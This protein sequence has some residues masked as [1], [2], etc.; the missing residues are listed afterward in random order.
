[1]DKEVLKEQLAERFQVALDG[2]LAAV[3]AA[4]EGRWIEA[5]EWVVRERFQKL[6][7]DCYQDVLQARI[8]STP[9]EVAGGFERGHHCILQAHAARRRPRAAAR[10]ALPG[11][12][13]SRPHAS[14]GILGAS[15]PTP[16]PGSPETG[17]RLQPTHTTATMRWVAPRGYRATAG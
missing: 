3:E 1:M 10:R 14:S 7:R 16:Q 17:G 4:P 12:S 15:R 6:M 5:S 11:F 13:V 2:V 8:Q 9:Q